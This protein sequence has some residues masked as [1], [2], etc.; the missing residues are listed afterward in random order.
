MEK[1]EIIGIDHGFKNMKTA[2]SCYRSA[3]SMLPSKPVSL[4]GI[5]E[6]RN[7]FY[8]IY[9]TPLSS[10][11]CHDKTDSEEY[12]L[13]TLVSMAKELKRRGVT[14]CHVRLAVGLPQKWYLKQKASFRDFLMRE[15]RL[16]YRFEGVKYSVI[17]DAVTVYSQGFPAMFAHQDLLAKYQQ[18]YV[19]LVD[20]GGETL[21]IIPLRDGQIYQDECKIDTHATNWL[22]SEIQECCES[23]LTSGID[24]SYILGVIKNG[25]K[26]MTGNAYE[27]LICRKL[28]EYSD[29]VFRRLKESRINLDLTPVCFLGGGASI[30]QKFGTYR[31]E[32]T[33]FITDICANAKGYEVIEKIRKGV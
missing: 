21:D 24:E 3:L 2:G 15:Q 17:L 1:L 20:I 18:G 22:A 28:Q 9:G 19:V 27:R 5:L 13:L 10:V 4:E 16:S 31:P 6:Y 29:Y 11:E 23:E 12:Y 8:T 32:M 25:N 26:N 30:I 33:D 7:K 14:D